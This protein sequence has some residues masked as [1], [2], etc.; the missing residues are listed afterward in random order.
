MLKRTVFTL[1]AS[2]IASTALVAP[3]MIQLAWVHPAD[4]D[5]YRV[6]ATNDPTAPFPGWPLLAT[7]PGNMTNIFLAIVPQKLFFRVTASNLWSLESLSSNVTNTPA[8]ITNQPVLN[9]SR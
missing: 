6:Y 9:L 8:P 4:V 2:A 7:V 5:A 3:Q 1:F